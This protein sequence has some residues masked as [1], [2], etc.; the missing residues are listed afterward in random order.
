[1]ARLLRR[2]G[3]SRAGLLL[4]ALALSAVALIGA[5]GATAD[6]GVSMTTP[7]T[8]ADTNPCTGEPFSGTG[9][10]HTVMTESVSSSGVLQHHVEMRIDG[11]Q[12]VTTPVPP[13]P[14]KR[15]V[16]KD[17]FDD[18][19]GFDLVSGVP[20]HATFDTMRQFI[21]VGEDGTFVMGDDFYAHF[22]AHLTYNANGD[23]TAQTVNEDVT[24]K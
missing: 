20:A 2:S 17:T 9:N 23:L 21:R 12:A 4:A 11:L 14:P 16:V 8:Y 5:T 15:Y 7:F 24:C 6:P 1:M 19:S 22:V 3:L 10:L 18:S 13:N